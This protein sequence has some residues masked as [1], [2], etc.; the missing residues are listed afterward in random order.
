MDPLTLE[1]PLKLPLVYPGKTA[2]RDVEPGPPKIP[3]RLINLPGFTQATVIDL[4]GF[5]ME[6]IVDLPGF[7][8]E[9]VMDLPGFNL[10][11]N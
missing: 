7:S 2:R 9:T 6:T 11:F 1:Y 4:P 5:S 10:D 8:M 3:V